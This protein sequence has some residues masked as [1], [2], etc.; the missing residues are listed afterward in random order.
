MNWHG[1]KP[2]KNIQSIARNARYNILRN[3]CKKNKINQILIGHQIDDVYEN[4]ILRLLRG[5]GLK[6][7]TSFDK[8]SKYKINDI[9]ILRPL[10]N[11]EKKD[12]IFSRIF[13]GKSFP[14]AATKA[15]SAKM[16]EEILE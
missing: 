1:K 3:E 10:I 13:L 2:T 4:F 9:E 6:G 16:L 14:I 7:L 15:V 12:L 5:S 8:V 11:V